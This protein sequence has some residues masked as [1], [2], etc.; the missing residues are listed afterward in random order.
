MRL[1][2]IGIIPARYASTRLP[3][4]PLID[5]LG[6]PMIQRVYEQASKVLK[7]IVVATD[8]K[9]IQ[10]TVLGF[11]GKVV[12]T[13]RKHPTGTDRINEAIEIINKKTK[14]KFNIIINIQGD[15][16]FIQPEQ[17]KK[18]IECFNNRETEIATL[19]KKIDSIKELIN[20]NVVKVVIDKKGNALYF[21]RSPIPFLREFPLEEWVKNFTYYKHIGVY[22]YRYDILKKITKISPS[23]IEQAESLEQLRWLDNGFKIKTAITKLECFSV[24]TKE[25]LEKIENESQNYSRKR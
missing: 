1:N 23:L 13:S 18:I 10:K 5:I 6:K 15:H 9:R 21:S 11:G 7:N 2:F 8:D 12:M 3:G 16:P 14:K 24:D 25:D 17:I 19:I 20:P 22:G 4:K